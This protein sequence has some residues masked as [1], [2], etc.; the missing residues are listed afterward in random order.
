MGEERVDRTPRPQVERSLAWRCTA[1]GRLRMFVDPAPNP[2]RCEG[3]GRTI[4][5][6]AGPAGD[7]RR[8]YR[9]PGS[10]IGER[11]RIPRPPSLPDG[12]D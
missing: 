12:F 1:C 10:I 11:R 4:L 5:V 9:E 3:C 8:T 7:R 6:A 2:A